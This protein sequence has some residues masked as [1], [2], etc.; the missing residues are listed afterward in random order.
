VHINVTCEMGKTDLNPQGVRMA[1]QLFSRRIKR[2][3]WQPRILSIC[4]FLMG[5]LGL[6]KGTHV[7]WRVRRS[8]I[9]CLLIYSDMFFW[10]VT[11]CVV[12]LLPFLRMH[13]LMHLSL[14]R[15]RLRDQVN[16]LIEVLTHTERS[17]RT[18]RSCPHR[19]MLTQIERSCP[20]K[21]MLTQIERSCPHRA[22]MLTQ[23]NE[24]WEIW[25]SR[26][27]HRALSIHGAEALTQ[28]FALLQIWGVHTEMRCSHRALNARTDART[29]K[30]FTQ[31]S[32]RSTQSLFGQFFAKCPTLRQL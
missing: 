26:R 28:S 32:A 11:T 14:I 2:E 6:T 29:E 13:A 7:C 4:T 9:C 23:S 30:R 25:N 16:T 21:A 8:D 27:S 24:F 5:S 12:T 1:S 20:H 15:R 17:A 19:A 31:R 22:I 3:Y 10:F 18:E